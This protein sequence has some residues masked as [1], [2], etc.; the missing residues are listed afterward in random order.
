MK[1][2]DLL[3]VPFKWGGRD[4][5]G[6]DC[7]GLVAEC[8]RRAGTPIADPFGE[9]SG[10]ISE[11]EAMRVRMQEINAREVGGPAPGRILYCCQGKSSHVAYILEGG[12]AIHSV[13]GKGARVSP[14]RAFP[15]PRFFEV[16]ERW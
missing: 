16:T 14:L 12:K 8:C 2:D 10:P 15:R 1:Y 11:G 9:L 7:W 5:R 4:R 6:M 3:G 13:I